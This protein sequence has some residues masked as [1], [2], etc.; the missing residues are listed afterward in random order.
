MDKVLHALALRL[1][2]PVYRIK[3]EMPATELAAWFLYF[4]EQAD[5]PELPD[6]EGVGAAGL[7]A[8]LGG[9]NG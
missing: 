3:A 1:A 6:V 7:F 5:G 2:T 4:K 8:G 9:G